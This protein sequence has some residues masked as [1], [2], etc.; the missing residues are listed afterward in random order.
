[1][2]NS[3]LISAML[4]LTKNK[5]ISAAC[6]TSTFLALVLVWFPKLV[7]DVNDFNS[8]G[9]GSSLSLRHNGLIFFVIIIGMNVCRLIWV[10][11]SIFDPHHRVVFFDEFNGYFIEQKSNISSIFG[12]HFN[13]F[14]IN[15]ILILAKLLFIIFDPLFTFFVWNFTLS[16]VIEITF[17]SN[18]II[19]ALRCIAHSSLWLSDYPLLLLFPNIFKPISN[20]LKRCSIPHIVD[21]KCNSNSPI[22]HFDHASVHLLP[23]CI[24]NE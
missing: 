1:M 19:E 20:A 7:I 6:T 17:I 14:Y 22:I 16:L 2:V 10:T 9:A 24:P 8:I 5:V 11:C 15:F 21:N 12:W 18:N 3:K 4:S 23:C 13:K